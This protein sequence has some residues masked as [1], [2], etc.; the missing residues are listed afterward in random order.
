[1]K[2]F[3]LLVVIALLC[4]NL[5]VAADSISRTVSGGKTLAISSKGR[6]H[7]HTGYFYESDSRSAKRLY[8]SFDALNEVERYARN[9]EDGKLENVLKLDF[10]VAIN[11]PEFGADYH[12][13]MDAVKKAVDSRWPPNKKPVV[14]VIPVDFESGINGRP[15]VAC[16][17]VIAIKES[18]KR[19]KAKEGATVSADGTL[20][21]V[22]IEVPVQRRDSAIF[23]ATQE[24]L[25]RYDIGMD[26]I[27]KIQTF[28]RTWYMRSEFLF[29]ISRSMG[30]CPPVIPTQ[31]DYRS[32]H[33][34]AEDSSV[35]RID[36]TILGELP[37]IPS[38]VEVN[39]LPMKINV[40]QTCRVDDLIYF[41]PITGTAKE[42]A[43]PTKAL[44][45]QHGVDQ[46]FSQKLYALRQGNEPDLGQR[47]ENTAPFW[48][49]FYKGKGDTAYL[50]IIGLRNTSP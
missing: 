43:E 41:A 38:E 5:G 28:S 42:F 30:S 48:L 34:S 37:Q 6:A 22:S 44:L 25:K 10:H 19:F 16:S 36:L 31:I 9:F 39:T 23:K 47:F 49:G 15:L 12:I 24:L 3:P 1:M 33:R 13:L 2:V 14:S 20:T 21:R 11:S 50:D 35:V 45:A 27:V 29:P 17:A 46:V 26:R 18:N 7:Y 8:G 4:L 40:S 32:P